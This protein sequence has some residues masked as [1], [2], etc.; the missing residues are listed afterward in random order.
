VAGEQLAELLVSSWVANC[1]SIGGLNVGVGSQVFAQGKSPL[2]PPSPHRLLNPTAKRPVCPVKMT[3][4]KHLPH[5]TSDKALVCLP[6]RRNCATKSRHGCFHC[7]QALTARYNLTVST[8][9]S[10][11]MRTSQNRKQEKVLGISVK[12][13][14]ILAHSQARCLRHSAKVFADCLQSC[15]V[16]HTRVLICSYYFE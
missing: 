11:A 5:P 6:S 15:C 13:W 7:L 16:H 12:P 8:P 9:V 1:G 2:G 10:A 14:N 4:T 3:R